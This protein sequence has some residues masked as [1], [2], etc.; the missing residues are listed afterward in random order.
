MVRPARLL[1]LLFYVGGM[2]A[3][4]MLLSPGTLP[5]VEELDMKVFTYADVIES[6]EPKAD[7]SEVLALEEQI[8]S[9]E[10]ASVAVDV[11]SDT[12]KMYF[13]NVDK[14]RAESR[15]PILFPSENANALSN[16]Y[17]SLRTLSGED[18]LIRI[19]H[20]GDSQLEG[21]RISDYLR[22]RLQ[23]RFGGCGVG[24]VPVSYPNGAGGP[25]VQKAS[26]NWVEYRSYG[27]ERKQPVHKN[28]GLLG[29][30]FKLHENGSAPAEAPY[31]AAVSY[32]RTGYVYKRFNVVEKIK[33]LY[34]NQREPL[35]MKY[36]VND[37]KIQKDSLPASGDLSIK[38]LYLNGDFRKIDLEFESRGNPDVYGVAFDC[39]RGIALDN[40]PMR[41]SSG[42]EFTQIG[43]N[44]LREQL[45]KLQVKLVIVQ[46][47]VNVVPAQAESYGF[48]E[49]SLKR[50]LQHIK[51]AAP[52]V[53]VLV[54]GVSDM[55]RKKGTSFE[56]YPNI[57]KI[58]EAQ[59]NAAFATGCAFWDLYKAMGGKNSM[60]SWV[61]AD[62]P[63]ASTD[64]THFTRR[65]ARIV[66]EMLY[67][68]LMYEYEQYKKQMR[69]L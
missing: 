40:I 65:G 69:N 60:S 67:N 10:E 39:N 37:G 14:S 1:L 55:A 46:F 36:A 3:L 52:D 31:R 45:Q 13:E 33:V 50:Q 16:F 41:G 64:Y 19:L 59:K 26:D 61:N 24:L 30:Y 2:C 28:Y 22:N 62:P 20:F 23:K 9:M 57:P 11:V 38:T 58:R 43:R 25:V 53:S 44:F 21:D 27:L 29:S 8:D 54:V 15:H 49:Y 5:L 6:P 68:E 63:M 34:R 18:Q 4:V 7:I 48:Y 51:S 56:S 47:G 32:S 66:G 17:A 42:L 35:V 12:G